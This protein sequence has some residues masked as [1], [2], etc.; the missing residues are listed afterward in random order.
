[1][2]GCGVSGNSVLVVMRSV[3]P[4]VTMHYVCRGT[5]H[6]IVNAFDLFVGPFAFHTDFYLP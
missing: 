5:V 2:Y 4:L 1:M 6:E 3:C